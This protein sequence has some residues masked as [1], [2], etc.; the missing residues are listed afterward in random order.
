M[1]LKN[2]PSC[3]KKVSDAAR[4]CPHCGH[5]LTFGRKGVEHATDLIGSLW[6]WIIIILGIGILFGLVKGCVNLFT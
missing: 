5:P 4:T 3:N 6:N 1:A 2:C